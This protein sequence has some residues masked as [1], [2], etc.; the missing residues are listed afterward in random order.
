MSPFRTGNTY[1]SHQWA[2]WGLLDPF[3]PISPGKYL[4]FSP[5]EDFG[6]ERPNGYLLGPNGSSRPENTYFS[7]QWAWD[8]MKPIKLSLIIYFWNLHKVP[9]FACTD[10]CC[11]PCYCANQRHRDERRGLSN[12]LTLYLE[13]RPNEVFCKVSVLALRLVLRGFQMSTGFFWL[14]LN[15]S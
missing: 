12:A 3:S 2:K 8:E 4:L 9:T 6:G 15:Y 1:F 11:L 7:H 14:F 13:E 5:V 10:F